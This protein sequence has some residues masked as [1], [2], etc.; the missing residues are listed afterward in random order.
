M[1][2]KVVVVAPRGFC[3]GVTRSID[4]VED[5]L[6]VFGSPV[7]IKHAIVHNKTVINDL[8]KK[9][10]VIVEKVEDVPEESVVIFS[11]HGSP[12]EDFK[13]AEARNLKV[14]DATCPLVTKVHFEIVSAIKKG[15]QPIYIGH[16]GH[17]EAEGVLGEAR[18]LNVEVPIVETKED[19]ENL[20]VEFG[21]DKEIVILTQTTFNVEKI[22]K[23]IRLIKEKFP[24]VIEPATKDICYAT[25]NRQEAIAEL[26]SEVDLVLV[27]GSKESSNSN[28]LVEVALNN[29][30]EAKLL[31]E[32]GEL[33]DNWLADKQT[34]GV[35]AGASAPE[36]R[37]QEIVDYF[38]KQG[39]DVIEKQTVEEKMNFTRPKLRH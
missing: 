31:D 7:Y 13:Q 6:K 28:R 24:K 15:Q 11:A 39:A 29:G 1:I 22:K 18:Q 30:A 17:V 34:V 37:V 25:T 16:L 20:P 2:K 27:V 38:Q 14:I 21:R 12:P 32:V 3:A 19:I 10:A 35:S 36:Y 23:L 8:E 26:A 9:G 5:A 33:D 4:I